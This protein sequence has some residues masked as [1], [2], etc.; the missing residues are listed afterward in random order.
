MALGL[1][2]VLG[3]NL[4]MEKREAQAALEDYRQDQ[5]KLAEAAASILQS[6]LDAAPQAAIGVI[7]KDL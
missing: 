2:L 1:T 7:V 4:A 3:V 5:M 6:R